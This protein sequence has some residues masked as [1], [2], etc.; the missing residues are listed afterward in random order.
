MCGNV[1]IEY[2]LT[3]K[4]GTLTE[5]V[6]VLKVC[7][8]GG[9]QFGTFTK[10]GNLLRDTNVVSACVRAR[11]RAGGCGGVCVARARLSC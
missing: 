11:A 4:T 3:D 10:G 8:I 2:V 5:N 1:Q 6:M 7:T 9:R